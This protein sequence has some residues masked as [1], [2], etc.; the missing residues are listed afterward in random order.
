MMD[1]N[2]TMQRE[3]EVLQVAAISVQKP[4]QLSNQNWNNNEA[5]NINRRLLQEDEY[6]S[7]CRTAICHQD[8]NREQS[9]RSQH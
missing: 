5:E 6:T 8:Q 2:E 7:K 3:H 1:P 9:S 4:H